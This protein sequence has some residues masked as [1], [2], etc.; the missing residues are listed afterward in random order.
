MDFEVKFYY[1]IGKEKWDNFV[2]NNT[3]GYAYH[4]WDVMQIEWY[5]CWLPISFAIINKKNNEILMC[6][7]LHYAEYLQKNEKNESVKTGLLQSRWGMVVKDG[8]QRKQLRKLQQYFKNTIDAF[9]KELNVVSFTI[10]MPPLSEHS[11]P[12]NCSLVN[13]LIFWGF[14][15][16]SKYTY[17]VD[18]SP[19]E[20]QLL[21]NCEQTTRQAIRKHS[22]DEKYEIVE[23]KPN[24]HDFNIYIDLHKITYNRTNGTNRILSDNFQRNLFFNLMPQGI[25]KVYFL[26][27]NTLDSPYVASIALLLY[28]HTAYYWWGSSINSHGIGDNKYLLFESMLKIKKL[29]ES[30]IKSGGKCYFETGGAA[31]Q[32]RNGKFKGLN[33]YK[34]CFGV[35]LHPIYSGNYILPDR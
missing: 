8:L 34:K 14:Q 20:D 19:S 1:Q 9:I 5:D 12:Q 2:N 33:D 10:S 13:E 31:P 7:V 27:D 18:L 32:L 24:E 26:K 29:N 4:L 6:I 28:N 35:F 22:L 11:N 21:K 30:Y 3:M 25:C 16:I 23:A 15:P 17:L